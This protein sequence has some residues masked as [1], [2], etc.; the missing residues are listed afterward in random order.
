[1]PVM[2]WSQA[3]ETMQE[4]DVK[5]E[6]IRARAPEFGRRYVVTLDTRAVMTITAYSYTT[7]YRSFGGELR[8][9]DG[10]RIQFDPHAI[11]DKII[12]P[13]LVPLVERAVKSVLALDGTYVN[14]H[15]SSF[16]DEQGVRWVRA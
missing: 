14:S 6:N 10:R 8:Q 4:G 15:P 9:P 16:M 2:S 12:D 5:V 3:S 11:A 1:M 13:L 7:E